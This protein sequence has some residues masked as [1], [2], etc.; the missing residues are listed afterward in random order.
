MQIVKIRERKNNNNTTIKLLLYY[1]RMEIY[2][3]YEK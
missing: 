1:F 3:A 2:A